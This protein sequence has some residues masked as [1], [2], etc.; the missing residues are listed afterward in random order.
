MTVLHF[1]PSVTVT[2][3]STSKEFAEIYDRHLLVPINVNRLSKVSTTHGKTTKDNWRKYFNSHTGQIGIKTGEHGGIVVVDVDN[4]EKG[5]IKNGVVWMKSLFRKHGVPKTPIVRS[6]SGGYHLYFLYDEVSSSL[7]ARTECA[8]DDNGVRYA[9]DIKNTSGY[10]VAPPSVHPTYTNKRYKWV[11][12][13]ELWNVKI[14]KIPEWILAD[15]IRSKP[16]QRAIIE[17]PLVST[18]ALHDT[19]SNLMNELR[20]VTLKDWETLTTANNYT[21][22]P[23][24]SWPWST[25]NE[26]IQEIL[27]KVCTVLPLLSPSRANNYTEWSNITRMLAAISRNYEDRGTGVV[28]WHLYDMWDAFS[29]Q[30]PEKYDMEKNGEMWNRFL[31]ED[32]ELTEPDPATVVFGYA[33]EDFPDEFEMWKR[34]NIWWYNL[35]QNHNGQAKLLVRRLKE[36]VRITDS[37]SCIGYIYNTDTA[38]WEEANKDRFRSLV[39]D[40]LLEIAEILRFNTNF[41]GMD[42]LCNQIQCTAHVNNVTAALK[43]QRSLIDPAFIDKINSIPHLFPIANGL[44]V[45]LKTGETRKRTINDLFSFESPLSLGDSS[46]K[47]FRKALQ[48]FCYEPDRKLMRRK[49]GYLKRVCGYFLTGCNKGRC[50]YI[51]HGAGHNGKS[52]LLGMLERL[53]C[54]LSVTAKRELLIKS[55]NSNRHSGAATPY[56]IDLKGRRLASYIESDITDNLNAELLKKITSSERLTGRELYSNPQ[57]FR[58]SSKVVLLTNFP[59]L[60]D[61]G[62]DAVM[63]RVRYIHFKKRFVSHTPTKKCETARDANFEE[64]LYTNLLPHFLAWCVEGAKDYY[65]KGLKE[66]E[67]VHLEGLKT[68]RKNDDVCMFVDECLTEQEGVKVELGVAYSNYYNWSKTNGYRPKSKLMFSRTLRKMGI[69]IRRVGLKWITSII[70]YHIVNN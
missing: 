64:E 63:D 13:R 62:D 30:A 6:G 42:K 28:Q 67:F 31:D 16:N 52:T 7:K 2:Q 66:P 3:M 17:R 1:S 54:D 5:E 50:F 21:T 55:R 34:D 22:N 47:K 65:T 38:L 40:H 37:G 68:I 10:V 53:L 48:D 56:L 18:L 49:L 24:W 9:V 8:I 69:T 39:V 4:K 60:F 44:V 32:K 33:K 25:P 27:I 20:N 45:D 46:N 59:P 26:E 36:T 19:L 58:C 14:M 29:Q 41:K 35:F 51:F 23:L 15:I 11:K 43:R 12:K 57:N 70:D 61:I